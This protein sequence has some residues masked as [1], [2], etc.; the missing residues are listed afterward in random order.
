MLA[1]GV[2]GAGAVMVVVMGVDGGGIYK[3]PVTLM[4]AFCRPKVGFAGLMGLVKPAGG[5]L[6]W[7]PVPEV[8][9]KGKA[10]GSPAP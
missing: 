8:P 3:A 4:T 6:P 1:W 7:P 10:P 5:W 9:P 2:V